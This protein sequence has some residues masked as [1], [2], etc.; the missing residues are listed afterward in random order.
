MAELV[1]LD[2]SDPNQLARFSNWDLD[3]RQIERGE[4]H[5]RV[6]LWPGTTVSLLRL[7]LSRAVHQTGAAPRDQLTFGIPLSASIASWSRGDVSDAGLVAFGDGA[8]FDGVTRSGFQALTLGMRSEVLAEHAARL[9]IALPDRALQ[10][11][12]LGANTDLAALGSI[13]RIARMML[14]SPAGGVRALDEDAIATELIMHL[15]GA[16][17]RG[18]T[19]TARKRDRALARAV[20]CM[21]THAAASLPI[22][23]ICAL[24][25]ASWRTLERAFLERF[26]IGPK[27]YYSALRMH[28]AR[29]DLIQAEPSTRIGE[30]ARR[31]GFWHMGKFAQDYRAL[32][33]CLPSE[34]AAVGAVHGKRAPSTRQ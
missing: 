7:E 9:G 16:Q 30:V 11:G 33:G 20:E 29:A 12:V 14:D 23:E 5:T 18:D 34:E 22:S 25:G 13:S 21:D 24:S 15:A 27:G 10:P 2:F 19:G 26:G 28:R 31:W 1:R 32:F 6:A 17:G 3:F 8:E 4:M